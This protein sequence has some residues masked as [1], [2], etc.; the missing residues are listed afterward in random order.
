MVPAGP[1]IVGIGEFRAIPEAA[2]SGARA[3]QL[4]AHRAFVHTIPQALPPNS[5]YCPSPNSQY[6]AV[7]ELPGYKFWC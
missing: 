7:R 3:L 4:P 5:P 1:R 2:D 6:L